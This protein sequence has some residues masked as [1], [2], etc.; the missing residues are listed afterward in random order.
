MSEI[1]DQGLSANED[2]L[3]YT[4]DEKTI[5]YSNTVDIV[6]SPVC[7]NQCGYCAFS[8]K[9]YDLLVPYATI[10]IFKAA[11]KDGAREANIVAG[12]RPD[13][14]HSIRAKFDVWGFNSYVEYIYTIAELAFLE[15]LLVNLNVG[16]LSVNE[17]KYLQD[18]VSTV[19][20]CLE[21]YD[22]EFIKEHL[23]KNSPSKDPEIRIK[24]IENAG[25]LNFPLNSGILI[26]VGETPEQRMKTL[27]KIRELHE[28]YGHIQ[29]VKINT[30]HPSDDVA[31]E[32]K[33]LGGVTK[34]TLLETIQLAREILPAEVD[35]TVPI[36]IHPE[37]LEFIDHGIRDLGQIRV[38]GKDSLFP[39]Y[40]FKKVEEYQKE[41]EDHGYKLFKRLPITNSFIAAQKYSKKL[42][43]FLDKYK[44]RLKENVREDKFTLVL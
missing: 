42:G 4:N 40:P 29:M 15:G 7:R 23:H 44:T 9:D 12:E 31:P 25:R 19:E 33:K 22:K 41:V 39:E 37:I 35:I 10:K 43:Q 34:E 20:M 3:P 14:F 16:Y 13:H 11:R 8:K 27:V 26:G 21:V 32:L 5:S 6:L 38:Y 2:I 18:I 24:F 28:E 17:L 36:N 1:L 30:F